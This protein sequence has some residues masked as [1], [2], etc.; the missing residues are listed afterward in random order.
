MIKCLA[1]AVNRNKGYR[2]MIR[3]DWVESKPYK[4]P[5][6]YSSCIHASYGHTN[7]VSRWRSRSVFVLRSVGCRDVRY[8]RGKETQA[9]RPQTLHTTYTLMKEIFY[10]VNP[11]FKLLY[12]HCS[13]TQHHVAMVVY[14]MSNKEL[15]PTSTTYMFIY[16]YIQIFYR[17]KP[18][19]DRLDCRFLP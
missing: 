7:I 17:F 19:I 12:T 4:I 13:R 8:S 9:C 16:V 18:R 10:S 3:K 11:L 14:N 2:V 5:G 15:S 6:M 1:S